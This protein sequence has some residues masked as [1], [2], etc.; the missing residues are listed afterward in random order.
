LGSADPNAHEAAPSLRETVTQQPAVLRAV[1]PRS[2]DEKA[3]AR[4]GVQQGHSRHLWLGRRGI[5]PR[6]ADGGEASSVVGRGAPTVDRAEE[7][8]WEVIG[9][10]PS[11]TAIAGHC[12]RLLFFDLGSTGSRISYTIEHVV[13]NRWISLIHSHIYAYMNIYDTY[14]PVRGGAIDATGR[15]RHRHRH[16]T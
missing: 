14:V 5:A 7:V 12:D 8:A 10:P 16:I 1:R 2:L 13:G 3:I 4:R 11:V 6:R 15:A 9:P